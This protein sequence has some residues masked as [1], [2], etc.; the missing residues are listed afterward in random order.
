MP[1]A[2]ATTAGAAAVQQALRAARAAV[3]FEADEAGAAGVTIAFRGGGRHRDLRDLPR[4]ELWASAGERGEVVGPGRYAG[5]SSGGGAARTPIHVVRSDFA[6]AISH[7]VAARAHT[8]PNAGPPAAG[9]W[10]SGAARK[11]QAVAGR[12]GGPPGR[13]AQN[14][15]STPCAFKRHVVVPWYVLIQRPVGPACDRSKRG[16]TLQCPPW[17]NS[18]YISSQPARAQTCRS[19][20]CS[21]CLL[22]R[23][24]L[25][26]NVD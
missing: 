7:F 18:Y 15:R 6:P 1:E 17:L 11:Q 22:V 3:R 2:R 25:D 8:P 14:V 9:C 21:H 4:G 5:E 26:Y 10:A 19:L 23:S 24:R 12:V 16:L 13:P 20:R